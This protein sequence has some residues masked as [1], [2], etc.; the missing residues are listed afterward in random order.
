VA[1][2][3]IELGLKTRNWKI[4]FGFSGNRKLETGFGL[5]G[6]WK[7]ETGKRGFLETGNLK[8]ESEVVP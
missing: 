2:R 4:G 8:L 1:A 3:A 5:S 6:N 7:L